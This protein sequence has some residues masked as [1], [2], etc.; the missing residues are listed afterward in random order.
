MTI[1][2]VD[3]RTINANALQ[4]MVIAFAAAGK[5][6]C[7]FTSVPCWLL[8]RD[9]SRK[10]SMSIGSLDHV[11]EDDRGLMLWHQ[12]KCLW[13][14]TRGRNENKILIDCVVNKIFTEAVNVTKLT[15]NSFNVSHKTSAE[16]INRMRDY[17]MH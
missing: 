13:R 3:H 11:R 1:H 15:Y 12:C 5:V 9:G 2:E 16:H 4:G 17:K 8:V 6:A 14:R 7:M 10:A